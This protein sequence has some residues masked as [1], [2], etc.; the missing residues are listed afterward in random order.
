M[1]SY[2]ADV[3]LLDPPSGVR[4]LHEKL[5]LDV[6]KSIETDRRILPTL[7]DPPDADSVELEGLGLQLHLQVRSDC[8]DLAAEAAG[9][10]IPVDLRCRSL[11]VPD[12]AQR[13]PTP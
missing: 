6:E 8:L 4:T 11:L 13:T 5:V 12:P 2:H 10:G 3:T 7:H 9:L 1:D